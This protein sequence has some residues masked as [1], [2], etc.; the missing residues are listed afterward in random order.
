MGVRF[1]AT[2]SVPTGFYRIT[3]D[4]AASYVEFCPPSS[5][6]ALSVERGYRDRARFGCPDGGEP[7]LKR[8]I[9][10]PGELVEISA[11][12]ISINGSL[13][14]NTTAQSLDSLGRPLTAWPFGRYRVTVDTV[15][16]ASTF[17]A[18]S[19]DSRYFGPIR[20]ADI[21]HRLRP[22]WTE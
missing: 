10:K 11:R 18:R 16:V 1:N 4:E 12:G 2:P 17:N 14:P 3:T 21:K 7:V 22:L 20:T 5:F 9:A 15:W 8:V 6:G 13:L 19:F